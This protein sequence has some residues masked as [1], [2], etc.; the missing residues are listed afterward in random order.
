MKIKYALTSLI[1]FCVAQTTYAAT[2]AIVYPQSETALD[3]RDEYP[4]A[5]LKLAL[6][7]TGVNFEVSPSSKPLIKSKALRQ[8]AANREINVVW[9]MTGEQRE[10]EF[11]PIR[12]PIYKGLI[13][14][15]VFLIKPQSR[16]N[17]GQVENLSD[18]V[19]MSAVQGHDWPDTKILQANDFEVSTSLSYDALFEMLDDGKADFFPRSIVEVWDE[20]DMRGANQ[21]L[22]VETSLG[23]HYPAAVYFFVNKKST[24]LARLIET[25]LESAIKSGKYD[26]LFMSTH[27]PILEKADM[28][29]RR[30]FSLYN[31][32]L[33]KRTPIDREE[34]WYTIGTEP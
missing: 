15:R 18:L 17:F 31:P 29:N 25:G 11:L 3:K 34:L 20:M 13:G 12:I 1:L 24:T 26:E 21:A 8:L 23:V 33:P 22:E 4:V 28:K 27:K 7:E 2:W 30:F 16:R 32:V 9:G 14:W 5:L 10:E 19:Q 6:Q